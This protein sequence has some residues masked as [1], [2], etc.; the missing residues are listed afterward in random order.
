MVVSKAKDSAVPAVLLAEVVEDGSRVAGSGGWG[1]ASLG[2]WGSLNSCLHTW[3]HDQMY[4][5]KVQLLE[6]RM[7]QWFHVLQTVLTV[8][9]A[10]NLVMR[11]HE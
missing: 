1:Q 11:K 4:P 10:A 5:K 7:S 3:V 2:G 9:K 8:P 6:A